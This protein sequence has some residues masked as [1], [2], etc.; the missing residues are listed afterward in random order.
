MICFSNGGI[1][2]ICFCLRLLV[3]HCY[4]KKSARIL[5]RKFGLDL[6]LNESRNDF[7]L[8]IFIHE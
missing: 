1:R 3:T 6:I 8:R 2:A 5:A 4:G 7:E